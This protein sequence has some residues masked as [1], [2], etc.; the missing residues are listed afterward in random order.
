MKKNNYFVL[1]PETILSFSN[2]I[3]F[4]FDS[5]SCR[6]QFLFVLLGLLFFTQCAFLAH[7]GAL[8]A[9]VGAF[10]HIFLCFRIPYVKEQEK[11]QPVQKN[12]EMCK[13]ISP[14]NPRATFVP[15]R[16]FVDWCLH[17]SP[18]FCKCRCVFCTF[19]CVLRFP[20]VESK[21]TSKCA[22]KT[23]L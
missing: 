18:R 13:H 22:K 12:A 11:H 5:T 3:E 15:E 19:S 4:V 6:T 2:E 17:I 23:E 14:R 20:Y 1:K 9:H 7:V 16:A 21:K 8:F 10:L